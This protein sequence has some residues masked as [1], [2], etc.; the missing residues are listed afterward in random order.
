M[1]QGDFSTYADLFRQCYV[2]ENILKR[3]QV[4]RDQAKQW[5]KEHGRSGS[6]L[7]PLGSPYKGKQSQGGRSTQPH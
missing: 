7:K 2:T 6:Y 5:H 4:E 3:A 1:S